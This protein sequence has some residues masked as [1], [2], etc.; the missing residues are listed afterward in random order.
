MDAA[1]TAS[2]PSAAA[3]W[4]AL[5]PAEVSPRLAT[6]GQRGLDPAEAASRLTRYGPN[7]LPDGRERGPLA[8]FLVIRSTPA[9]RRR[10]TAVEAGQ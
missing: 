3:A 2:P 7:G 5:S 9:P 1:P 6:G 8:R 10:V 4:H